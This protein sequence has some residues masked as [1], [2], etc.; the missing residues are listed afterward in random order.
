MLHYNTK[1]DVKMPQKGERITS[2]H[3]MIIF[4]ENIGLARRFKEVYQTMRERGFMHNYSSVSQN[5]KYLIEQGKIVRYEWN[6][7]PRYGLPDTR[8]DGT[9]YIIIKNPNLPDETVEL[10]K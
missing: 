10:G 1:S 9:R 4:K 6:K 3:L 7:N 8:E 2:V 5:L